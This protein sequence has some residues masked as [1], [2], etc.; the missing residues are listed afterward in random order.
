MHWIYVLLST[1]LSTGLTHEIFKDISKL[2]L[3]KWS[4][5]KKISD[6]SI[7][8]QPSQED[9]WRFSTL[10]IEYL[11][12]VELKCWEKDQVWAPSRL[13]LTMRRGLSQAPLPRGDSIDSG[14]TYRG[15]FLTASRI[16]LGR[17]GVAHV[18]PPG[19]AGAQLRGHFHQSAP[20]FGMVFLVLTG[21]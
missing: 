7:S 14:V 5:P 19:G 1:T 17:N 16:P 3:P 10:V 12:Y 18:L 13:A 8:D 4:F 21:G 9:M 11:N 2:C 6:P 20:R 15:C